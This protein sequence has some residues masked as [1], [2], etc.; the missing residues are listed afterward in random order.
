M[1]HPEGLAPWAAFIPIRYLPS[2]AHLAPAAPRT[3]D[4]SRPVPALRTHSQAPQP[5]ACGTIIPAPRTE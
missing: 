1:Q 2:K 5:F 4:R 3:P